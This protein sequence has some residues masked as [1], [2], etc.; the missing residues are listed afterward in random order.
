MHS[1]HYIDF[2]QSDC[3]DS[4][5]MKSKLLSLDK[6]ILL[7]NAQKNQNSQK[8]FN[9]NPKYKSKYLKWRKNVVKYYAKE[10][11]ML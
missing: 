10:L 11:R 6:Q 1:F 2:F 7:N 4:S 9:H 3:D 5:Q 8:K